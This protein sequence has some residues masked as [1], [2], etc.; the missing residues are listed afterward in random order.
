[1]QLLATAGCTSRLLRNR[2]QSNCPSVA[3]C[4]QTQLKDFFE[5]RHG[6]SHSPTALHPSLVALF[7]LTSTC[8]LLESLRL[9]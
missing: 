5:C 7:P 8:K 1:M 3:C 2:E 6:K 4:E 9:P